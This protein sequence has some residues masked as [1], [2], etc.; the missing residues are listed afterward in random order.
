[1]EFNET[2][3]A[4]RAGYVCITHSSLKHEWT[5]NESTSCLPVVYVEA[6]TASNNPNDDIAT[7][8][9]FLIQPVVC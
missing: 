4:A 8:M 3:S 2:R 1:M 9:R 7:K 5:Y 6:R